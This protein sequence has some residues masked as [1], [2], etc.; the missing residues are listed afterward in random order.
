LFYSGDDVVA[1]AEIRKLVERTGY[2]PV[3]LGALDVGGP[4]TSPPLGPLA[5]ISLI[6]V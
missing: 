2:F 1:K 3:D 5:A 4:L 6:K